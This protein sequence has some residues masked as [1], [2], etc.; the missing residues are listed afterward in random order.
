LVGFRKHLEHKPNVFNLFVLLHL[1][2]SRGSLFQVMRTGR[3][4]D[5]WR[6]AIYPSTHLWTCRTILPHQTNHYSIPIWRTRPFLISHILQNLPFRGSNLGFKN[7]YT[8]FFGVS[9]SCFILFLTCWTGTLMYG[10]IRPCIL[11]QTCL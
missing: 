11:L 3:F 6:Y 1:C 7:I 5:V 8:Y 4:Q 9:I 10:K 2:Q